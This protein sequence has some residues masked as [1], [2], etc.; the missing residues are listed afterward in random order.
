VKCSA[1]TKAGSPCGAA[2]GPNGLCFF[3]ANPAQAQKLGQLGGWKNRKRPP[4]DLQVPEDLTVAHL[5][6][7]NAHAMQYLLSGDLEPR[8]AMAL[9]QMSSLQLRILEGIEYDARLTLLENQ[10]AGEQAG[11][12]TAP[13]DLEQPE[14]SLTVPGGNS[15]NE[16]SDMALPTPS[17][18]EMEIRT[19]SD[20]TEE[21]VNR[22]DGNEESGD[23][24]LQGSEGSEEL[25]THSSDGLKP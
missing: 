9:V 24:E 19:A 10:I 7:I 3:H 15:M 21:T 1:A 2:A 20:V 5:S 25:I 13:Q 4:V 14:E 16:D 17:E 6:R 18:R 12:L 8:A 11:V 22:S 23:P